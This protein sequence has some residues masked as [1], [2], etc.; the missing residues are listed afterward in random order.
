M[1]HVPDITKN[2]L[3]VFQLTKD[4]NVIMEFTASS[5]FVKDQTTNQVLFHG[6]L[7][8]GLY[9]WISHR[10]NMKHYKLITF[11]HLFG[12]QD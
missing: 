11:L 6:T 7:I 2:L 8:N 3:S 9:N 1:L 4:N 12:T 10:L 5:C